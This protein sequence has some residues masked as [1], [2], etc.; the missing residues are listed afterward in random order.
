MPH[1]KQ[2]NEAAACRIMPY[3]GRR[4][5][6]LNMDSMHCVEHVQK[7]SDSLQMLHMVHTPELLAKMSRERISFTRPRWRR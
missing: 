1:T 6:Q 2:Y 5:E 4:M 7:G 3:N